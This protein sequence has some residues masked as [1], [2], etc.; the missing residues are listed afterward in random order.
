MLPHVQSTDQTRLREESMTST[1]ME[2]FLPRS[3]NMRGLDGRQWHQEL[4]YSNLCAVL[5]EMGKYSETVNAAKTTLEMGLDMDG[6]MK[7]RLLNRNLHSKLH[8]GQPVSSASNQA[9]NQDR[10][11]LDR[12]QMLATPYSTP[13]SNQSCDLAEARVGSLW[14]R[15]VSSPL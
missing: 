8:L 1:S 14:S 3:K 7:Q 13:P 5:F 11:R 15:H 4:P 10:L 2:S 9:E 12:H 6:R